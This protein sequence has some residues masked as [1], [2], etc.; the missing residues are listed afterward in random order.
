MTWKLMAVEV[1]SLDIDKFP[2]GGSSGL[3]LLVA[4]VEGVELTGLLASAAAADDLFRF[5]IVIQVGYWN[6]RAVGVF[7]WW[8]VFSRGI[9]LVH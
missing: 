8:M 4:V 5:A 6:C 3:L 9:H 7:W 2:T 1:S